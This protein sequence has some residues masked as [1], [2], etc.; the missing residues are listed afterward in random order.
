MKKTK[1]IMKRKIYGVQD[2]FANNRK[3]YKD[4]FLFETWENL[5][6]KG[7][8]KYIDTEKSYYNNYYF[9]NE[10]RAKEFYEKLW[11]EYHS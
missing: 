3:I 6:R 11:T 7:A 4:L 5:I 2:D 9:T 10:E 1:F 8:E